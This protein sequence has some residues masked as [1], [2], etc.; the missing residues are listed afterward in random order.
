M[1][2]R[3]HFETEFLGY[4]H[5]HQNCIGAVAM[6]MNVA[7]ALHDLDQRL[8]LLVAARRDQS[9]LAGGFSSVV[10][11]PLL[12]IFRR[13]DECLANHFFHAKSRGRVAIR[14][15]RRWGK[16]GTLR[17]F[18]QRKF[19]SRDSALERQFARG[20]APTQLDHDRLAADRVGAAVQNIGYRDAPGEIVVD[21]DVIGVQYV[22]NIGHRGNRRAAFIYAAVHRNVRVAINN[23]RD[24]KLPG[25]V[26]DHRAFGSFQ[27]RPNRGD[28]AVLEK[29]AAG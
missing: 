17:I 16:A 29:F 27:I 18:A 14:N 15:S 5:E 12:F 2:E 1:L 4:A 22:S 9:L 6:R 23:S 11:V 19:D 8:E 13:L 25:A 7:F 24:Y 3:S 20:L 21:A 10:I 26:N 28:F